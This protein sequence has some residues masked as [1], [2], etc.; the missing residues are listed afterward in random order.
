MLSLERLRIAVLLS[1]QLRPS[2]GLRRNFPRRLP[3]SFKVRRHFNNAQISLIRHSV[4]LTRFSRVTFNAAHNYLGLTTE[5]LRTE[6]AINDIACHPLP[7]AFYE[8]GLKHLRQRFD[9]VALASDSDTDS[10][11]FSYNSSSQNTSKTSILGQNGKGKITDSPK[12]TY[13]SPYQGQTPRR[14]AQAGDL[15]TSTGHSGDTLRPI[16]RS[17]ST[18]YGGRAPAQRQD[19]SPVREQDN[20]HGAKRMSADDF[21]LRDEVMSCIAKSIGLIQ[22]P[23][24]GED[25]LEASPHFSPSESRTAVYKSSFG[26]LSLLDMGDDGTSSVT[27]ASSVMTDGYMSGLDNEVEILFFPAGSILATAGERNTGIII[28]SCDVNTALL[29]Y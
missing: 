29:I 4:I 24:S 17:A 12:A 14:T 2:V 16:S 20:N 26:S 13:I 10:D 27:A 6:K 19:S 25:S 1:F 3:T 22:P 28:P 15:H 23:I 11:Y 8:T 21:D 9:G 5:V 18:I 7:P